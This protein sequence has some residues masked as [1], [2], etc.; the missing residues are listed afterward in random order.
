MCRLGFRVWSIVSITLAFSALI[1]RLVYELI[2]PPPTA[3]GTIVIVVLLML[4]TLIF[5]A[6]CLYLFIKPSLKKVRSLLVRV[7][8]MIIITAALISGI[9]HYIRFI[10]SPECGT[11]FSVITATL[12]LLAGISAYLLVL[13]FR[14]SIRK[15]KSS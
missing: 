12:L 3:L 9:I 15:D 10:P 6:L 4:A 5:Y 2:P 13:G 14:W 7:W 11:I 8:F 1:V